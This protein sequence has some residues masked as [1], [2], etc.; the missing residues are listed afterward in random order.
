MLRSVT[1]LRPHIF[2][3]EFERRGTESLPDLCFPRMKH[4]EKI[5]GDT[6]AL[7]NVYAPF[8]QLDRL[9]WCVMRY[10][11]HNFGEAADFLCPYL[12]YFFFSNEMRPKVMAED[13]TLTYF[14]A[15]TKI[16]ELWKDVRQ[17][18]RMYCSV[19]LFD[20]PLDMWGFRRLAGEIFLSNSEK[21]CGSRVVVK[22]RY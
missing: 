3:R 11:L 4:S 19:C 21:R 15:A 1:C 8:F 12:R 9:V 10:C 16:S 13:S 6:H 7:R 17:R 22:D 20:F 5:G 2:P 18:K 14:T